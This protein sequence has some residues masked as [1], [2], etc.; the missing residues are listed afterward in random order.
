MNSSDPL[1]Q[2]LSIEELGLLENFLLSDTAPEESM[3][4][5]EMIDGYMTALIAGPELPH[6]D[7]WISYI[8]DQENGESPS[9]SSDEEASLLREFLL[10][11][12]NS[13]AMQFEEEPD[14]F[15]PL[16]EKLSYPDDEEMAAAV[17]DWALGFTT[18]M[19]LTHEAWKPFFSDDEIAVL[20]FPIFVLGKVTDDYESMSDDDIDDLVRRLPDFVIRIH[21]YWEL[22]R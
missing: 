1:L 20:A 21:E 6:P 4:S 17:E 18:G 19:E 10:R 14:G 12:M 16:Y 15:L 8:W 7:I 5:I 13:I 22:N 2:P 9:F 11:H 3:T